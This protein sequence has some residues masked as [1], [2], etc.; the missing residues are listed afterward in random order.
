MIGLALVLV[1]LGHFSNARADGS[2]SAGAAVSA[3]AAASGMAPGTV[4]TM[5]NWQQFQQFMPDG[6]IGLFQGGYWWKMPPDV[7]MEVGPTVIHPLP[8]GYVAATEKYASQVK[9]VTL[10]DGGL[11]V[12]NYQGGI[13]FPAPAHPH[14]GWKILADF[15]FRYMP[16]LVVNTP[17]N[18]GFYCTLDSFSNAR[19]VKGLWVYRQLA[20]NTDPGIPATIPGTE[21]K[22][23]TTWFM[24]EEPEEQKYTATLTIGYADLSRPEEMYIF[25]PALRRAQ[26]V[27][28][29]ARCASSG[30]DTTAEDGRFG[31]DSNIPDFDARLIGQRK[32]L[33]QMDVGTA[34]ANFPEDYDMP[35]GWSKPSWGK[36]ELRDAYVLDIRKL[37]SKAGGYCYGKRIMYIDK[38]FYGPLW[39]DLYDA[40]M[41][42]WKVALLQ[43]IVINVPGSGPQNSSG[44]QY[45]HYWDLQNHHATFSGP[46]DGH[47][48]DVLIND[49]APKQ[50]EDIGRYTTPGGLSEVM[51]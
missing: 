6:M 10:P 2:G 33:A 3:P 44:A 21:G 29:A 34:G 15:W 36:W 14:L 42:L 16:H 41:Q 17:D 20:Y 46:N 7:A 5:Q 23:Y 30:S 51:R 27:S 40:K 48:Y 4:I 49:E 39:Q 43:P 18:L 32:I 38:Q 24:V 26:P 31:F 50:Y 22:F 25:L 45:S 1:L 37:Q 12:A 47:G 11:T 9:L 13:P 8:Q 35:L 19:C 28:A